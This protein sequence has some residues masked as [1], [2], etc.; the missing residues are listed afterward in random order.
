MGGEEERGWGGEEGRVERKKWRK[1]VESR[2][3]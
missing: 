2:D 3:F 1:R